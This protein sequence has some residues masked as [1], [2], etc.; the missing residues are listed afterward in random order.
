MQGNAQDYE[1][2]VGHH[3]LQPMT[4]KSISYSCPIYDLLCLDVVYI[5]E[6]IST[7]YKGV[8]DIDL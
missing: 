7:L 8:L 4:I 3:E 2:P 1:I 6:I 5:T